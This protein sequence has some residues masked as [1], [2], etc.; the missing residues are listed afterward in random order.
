MKFIEDLKTMSIGQLIDLCEKFGTTYND[1]SEYIDSLV[2]LISNEKYETLFE[3]I[4]DVYGLSAIL[5]KDKLYDY[6]IVSFIIALSD[7]K[8]TEEEICDNIDDLIKNLNN[9]SLEYFLLRGGS[10]IDSEYEDIFNEYLELIDKYFG[11]NITLNKNKTIDN[12]ELVVDNIAVNISGNYTS[13]I[14]YS[15]VK[16]EVLVQQQQQ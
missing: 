9:Y 8:I 11:I 5:N 3:F 1:I 7:N 2:K 13:D 4:T 14:D 16:K 6:T 10:I 12:V 15:E